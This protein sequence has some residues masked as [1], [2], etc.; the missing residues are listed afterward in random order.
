MSYVRQPSKQHRIWHRTDNK[1]RY[2]E[3]GF[4]ETDR[5]NYWNSIFNQ[6]TYPAFSHKTKCYKRQKKNQQKQGEKDTRIILLQLNFFFMNI[7]YIFQS[8]FIAQIH[9][10]KSSA[11]PPLCLRY[12]SV[13]PPLATIGEKQCHRKDKAKEKAKT[14][15]ILWNN[16]IKSH[17]FTL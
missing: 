6:I 11:L 4:S 1:D 3:F 14:N 16:N 10:H 17:I 15:L 2:P 7:W 8:L 13:V 9:H 5:Y 12:A